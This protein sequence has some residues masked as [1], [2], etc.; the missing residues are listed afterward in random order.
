M[1]FSPTITQY[2]NSFAQVV[3]NGVNASI[4][5]SLTDAISNSPLLLQ[6]LENAAAGGILTGFAVNTGSANG[7]AAEMSNKTI[8]FYVDAN[9]SPNVA[10]TPARFAFLL[11]HEIGHA[12][13]SP[14]VQQVYQNFLSGVDTLSSRSGPQDYTQLLLA[15]QTTHGVD[16]AV[17]HIKGWND[18]VSYMRAVNP[19]VT[20]SQLYFAGGSYSF[21]FM[22]ANQNAV[23]GL[24]FNNDFTVNLTPE[25]IAAVVTSYFLDTRTQFYGHLTYPEFYA[26]GELRDII[27]AT[28]GQNIVI[29]LAKLHIDAQHIQS[30]NALQLTSG[31]LIRIHDA[32]AQVT[33]TFEHSGLG[34]VRNEAKPITVGTDNEKTETIY[35]D[36][37]GDYLKTEH[38]WSI[39]GEIGSDTLDKHGNY[40]SGWKGADGVQH[41]VNTHPDGSYDNGYYSPLAIHIDVH[42]AD[43]SYNTYTNF[44]DGTY[45]REYLNSDGSTGSSALFQNGSAYYYT[46]EPN[47]AHFN[48]EIDAFG[49][50]WEDVL[51]SNGYH[52][53]SEWN[54]DGSF[55]V[56]ER[57][58]SGD[59]LFEK[60]DDGDGHILEDVTY[61]IDG[62]L[63]KIDETFDDGSSYHFVHDYRDD[64]IDNFESEKDDDGAGNIAEIK[65]YEDGA[66]EQIWQTANGDHGTKAWMVNGDYIYESYF[67]DGAFERVSFQ[68]EYDVLYLTEE[69]ADGEGHVTAVENETDLVLEEHYIR[70]EN[71]QIDYDKTTW[72]SDND[73]FFMMEYTL[74]ERIGRIELKDAD[75]PEEYSIDANENVVY[76]GIE[77]APVYG[78][79]RHEYFV[80]GNAGTDQYHTVEYLLL[81]SQIVFGWEYATGQDPV[82]LGDPESPYAA[83][84]HG[85]A[86]SL[87]LYGDVYFHWPQLS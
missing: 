28:N 65:T 4:Y 22:D 16:E 39:N 6:Q 10:T 36:E 56:S 2:L 52:K 37:N 83:E 62:E 42:N 14:T 41:W 43:G 45:I 74:S 61:G 87:A 50:K 44:S 49:N 7:K 72:Y 24:S 53:Y 8:V 75:G 71:G 46:A 69:N 11:G 57:S 23:K 86:P 51:G 54:S 29:D 19:G 66:K 26:S 12:E 55:S 32:T 13:Y 58:G 60:E 15:A 9:G 73:D 34:I 82:P 77:T 78:P 48:W 35:F 68:S 64:G 30:A 3:P 1:P 38:K 5:I 27:Q 85:S 81:G 80:T 20:P 59:Y 47:G 17:A 21:S 67:V 84:L 40:S 18:M 70:D 76:H 25:N 63:H 31:Q 79:Y 33:Y